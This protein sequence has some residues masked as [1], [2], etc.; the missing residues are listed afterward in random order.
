MMY[1][2][3]Q[4]TRLGFFDKSLQVVIP[5]KYHSG[6]PWRSH[7]SDFVEGY[8]L[9]RRSDLAYVFVDPF[10]SELVDKSW[11]AEAPKD[12]SEGLAAVACR[13][14]VT[15]E[16]LWGFIDQT[17]QLVIPPR[18]EKVNSFHNGL[19]RVL[20]KDDKFVGFIDKRGDWQIKG[21]FDL[22]GEFNEGVA[23]ACV[24]GKWGFINI[25]GDWVIP[26]IFGG[27]GRFSE[28]LGDVQINGSWGGI[29]LTGEVVIEPRFFFITGFHEGLSKFRDA[30]NMVA[31]GMM[32]RNGN[33]VVESKFANIGE[34]SNGWSP[35]CSLPTVTQEV[36]GAKDPKAR[37]LWGVIDT[38][39]NYVIEQKFGYIHPF[40]GDLA[41]VRLPSMKNQLD[42]YYINKAGDIVWRSLK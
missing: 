22:A 11:S 37:P 19:A 27:A 9:V 38:A 15:Q 13:N 8:A 16:I 10:G 40:V 28:G 20:T 25:D 26:P 33:V 29:N 31:E 12:F 14:N 3:Y 17:G 5:P 18:F 35:A 30:K 34:I 24:D 6:N 23:G 41:R 1:S 7:F 2:F 32:D 4:N 42:T 39:G 21:K 36:Q